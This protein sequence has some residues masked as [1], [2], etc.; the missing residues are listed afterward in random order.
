MQNHRTIIVIREERRR[1]RR[2]SRET[3]R[4]RAYARRAAS[5]ERRFNKYEATRDVASIAGPRREPRTRYEANGARLHNAKASAIRKFQEFKEEHRQ[6]AGRRANYVAN[7]VFT[8]RMR[9]R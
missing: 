2:P 8:L 1:K 7:N 5:R 4:Q 6:T 3:L 9:K